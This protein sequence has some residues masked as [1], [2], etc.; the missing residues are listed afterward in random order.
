MKHIKLFEGYR[1]KDIDEDKIY[2]YQYK[3]PWHNA[4]EYKFVIGK[5]ELKDYGFTIRGYSYNEDDKGASK[6]F[7]TRR[8]NEWDGLYEATPD[9][10]ED[11]ESYIN[12]E[13]YNL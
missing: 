8:G 13:K 9:E 12:A 7:M 4:D 1:K 10:A 11:Y 6:A 5:I 3:E 2:I